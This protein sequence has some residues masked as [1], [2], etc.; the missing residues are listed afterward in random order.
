MV[1]DVLKTKRLTL[2]GFGDKKSDVDDLV[3]GCNNINVTK[4]LLLLPYPY[5]KKDAL[6][7]I[8]HCQKK[9]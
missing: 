1:R 6:E 5:Q 2:R 4:W 8:N 3:K 7:W 9:L